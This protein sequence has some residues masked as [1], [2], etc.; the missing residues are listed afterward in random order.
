MSYRPPPEP[1]NPAWHPGAATPGPNAGYSAPIPPSGPLSPNPPQQQQ[2]WVYT[3]DP[4]WQG[5]PPPTDR[6]QGPWLAV[7]AVILGIA[8]CVLPFLPID[9]TGVRPLIGLPFAIAGL[10]L[11]IVGSVGRRRAKGL[12][13]TGIILSV[14]ALTVALIMLPQLM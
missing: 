5:G 6:R 3:N 2:P 11:G 13:V 7:G 4:G 14:L 9:L 8:G 1:T 10:V 12:A